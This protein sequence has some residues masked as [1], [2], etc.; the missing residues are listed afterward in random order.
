MTGPIQAREAMSVLNAYFH[1][2][3]LCG[4]G[5]YDQLA[6][7][8]ID[9]DRSVMVEVTSGDNGYYRGS[10]IA[11]SGKVYEFAVDLKDPSLSRW[12]DVSARANIQY[13]LYKQALPDSPLVLAFD[14]FWSSRPV[15][16]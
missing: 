16:G 3:T 7:L 4:Q 10:L 11:A 9:P 1:A 8:G 13:Q 5:F 12:K 14:L 6:V 15:G 2:R